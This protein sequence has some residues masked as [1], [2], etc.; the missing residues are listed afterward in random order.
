MRN[1]VQDNAIRGPHYAGVFVGKDSAQNY[2][3]DNQITGAEVVAL[4]TARR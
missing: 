4:E 3:L 2:V 1:I